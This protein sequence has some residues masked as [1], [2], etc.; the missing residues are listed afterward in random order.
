MEAFIPILIVALVAYG[1]WALLKRITGSSRQSDDAATLQRLIGK[2]NE[3]SEKLKAED[4]ASAVKIARELLA[5]PD[6]LAILDTETTGIGNDCEIIQVG[7]IDGHGNTLLDTLV[8][9]SNAMSWPDAEAIHG[10]SPE[11]VANATGFAEIQDKIQAA[12]S[13]RQV[14]IFNAKYDTRLILQSA[15]AAG[16]PAPEF[17]SACAMFLDSLHRAK[18]DKRRG[19]YRWY[20]LRGGDHTAI[21]DCQATLRLLTRIAK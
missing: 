5:N 19:H 11:A 12:V 4:S 20:K 2:Q 10:I 7:I 16:C 1:V 14:V 15:K 9:P 3:P 6:S 13:G 8:K 18:W 21:G 17:E